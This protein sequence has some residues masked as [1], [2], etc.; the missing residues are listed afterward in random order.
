MPFA[1]QCRDIIGQLMPAQ[2]P[3]IDTLSDRCVT[4][5][6]EDLFRMVRDLQDNECC[7]DTSM[8]VPAGMTFGYVEYERDW[9]LIFKHDI[10]GG[11]FTDTVDAMSKNPDDPTAALF[12]RLDTLETYR[13]Q[14]ENQLTFKM[15]W[16]ELSPVNSNIWMQES[17]PFE[18]GADSR[19]AGF[20]PIR[21]HFSGDYDEDEDGMGPQLFE[22]LLP[23]AGEG[24][25]ADLD[26]GRCWWGAIGAEHE[27]NCGIP[28]PVCNPGSD[29]HCDVITG[30][31]EI[32][33]GASS[34]FADYSKSFVVGKVELWVAAPAPPP[35]FFQISYAGTQ[36]CGGADVQAGQWCASIDPLALG[37]DSSDL[38]MHSCDT[39]DPKQG[40]SYDDRTMALSVEADPTMCLTFSHSDAHG[41]CEPYTLA[42]CDPADDHQK[43]VLEELPN[44]DPA[45]FQWHSIAQSGEVG[46]VAIDLNGCSPNENQYI[47]ACTANGNDAKHWQMRSMHV[48]SESDWTGGA[49]ALF[50]SAATM[51]HGTAEA[52]CVEKGGRL[53][54]LDSATKEGAAQEVLVDTDAWIA[55]YCPAENEGCGANPPADNS[56]QWFW[57]DEVGRQIQ[58]RHSSLIL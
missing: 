34:C 42:A 58:V 32:Q 16:P 53:A 56:G 55:L 18:P 7:V 45:V 40:F 21:L 1:D 2:Q 17:N 28:G 41:G 30:A 8:I 39:N 25:L 31:C 4:G 57:Y 3:A 24:A 47:W 36:G 15:V 52:W 27:H 12:S 43:F 48:E 20:M 44:A 29:R 33:E 50:H 38:K 35:A 10:T 54:V 46:E 51:T 13:D 26:A 11:Y 22:G 5:N 37:D 19:A 6:E 49:H 9:V 14:E 23:A